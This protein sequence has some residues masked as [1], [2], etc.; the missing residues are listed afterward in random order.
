MRV[1]IAEDDAV[2]RKLLH[3]HLEKWGHEVVEASDGNQAWSAFERAKPE[4]CIIDW[5]MPEMDGLALIRNI[6]ATRTSGY[7]YTIMLTAKSEKADVV[8]GMEAGADDFIA[9]PF[10]REELHARLKAGA[11]ILRLQAQLMQAEKNASVGGLALGVAQQIASP[12]NQAFESVS[13]LRRD[14]LAGMNILSEYR[15]AGADLQKS[16]P[17]LLSE[18]RQQESKMNIDA[19]Y[20]RM[21]PSFDSCLTSLSTV[22][23][24]VR[25]LRDFATSDEF[26]TRQVNLRSAAEDAIAMVR[27]DLDKKTIQM[28]AVVPAELE[29]TCNAGKLKKVL[30]NVLTNAAEASDAGGRIDLRARELENGQVLIEVQDQGHGIAPD[31][32]PHVF[33]PFFSTRRDDAHLGLGL[34]VSYSIVREHGGQIDAESK[35]RGATFRIKLPIAGKRDS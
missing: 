20:E 30:V 1:L 16:N 26:T 25:N 8:A 21:A 29:L 2:T 6:R 24:L 34:S 17:K 35:G 28:S 4:L 9:K 5:M 22:R 31:V 12:V 27:T 23:E 13:A 11:R 32:L 3:S 14:A 7:I 10:D 18:I 33:E 15:S 19:A